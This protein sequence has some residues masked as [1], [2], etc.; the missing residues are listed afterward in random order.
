MQRGMP[1]V[2]RGR[3]L[4][5]WHPA[6]AR[7]LAWSPHPWHSTPQAQAGRGPHRPAQGPASVRPLLVAVLHGGMDAGHTAGAPQIV[8]TAAAAFGVFCLE[9]M[10]IQVGCKLCIGAGGWG[11][12]IWGEPVRGSGWRKIMWH[13]AYLVLSSAS[14]KWHCLCCTGDGR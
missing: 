11:R 8:P 2:T 10:T 14:Q 13:D 4:D 3:A 9:T 12:G 5:A 7:A 6:P 1:L